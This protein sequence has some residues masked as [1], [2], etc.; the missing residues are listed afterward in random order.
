MGKDQDPEYVR[1]VLSAVLTDAMTR[2]RGPGHELPSRAASAASAATAARA[3]SDPCGRYDFDLAEFPLFRLS[4][5]ATARSGREPLRYEDTIAGPDG[6]RI[7]RSWTIY[8][9]PFGFG[10]PSAQVL[11][12]DLLQLYAEQGGRGATIQFGTLRSLLVRRGARNPS[13]R[14]YDRVRRDFDALRGY[15]IHCKSAFWDPARRRYVDMNWR[16]FG[17]V[18]YFRPAAGGDADAQ[19]YGF[20]EV[21][22]VLQAAARSRGLFALGFDP[23]QFHGLKPMEQRLAV[24]LAKQFASQK[25]HRRFVSDMAPALPIE[26]ARERD[27]RA[28]LR[29]AAAELVASGVRILAAFRLEPSRVGGWV[30]TFVRGAAPERPY[31]PIGT[32]RPLPPEVEGAVTRITDAVGSGD[33]HGW[34]ALCAGRLVTGPSTGRSGS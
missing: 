29:A 2:V 32:G 1:S 13:K 24:Y 30:A 25:L 6:E 3:E 27:V 21:S 14:D 17:A 10:G 12:F 11:L 34:W 15:D 9:G 31:Q 19:P 4:K 18:F 22:P 16:L 8:P 23:G 26:A 28:T 33:D 20:V 5:R 7:G